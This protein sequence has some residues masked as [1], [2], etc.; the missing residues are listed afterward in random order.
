MDQNMDQKLDQKL[1]DKSEKD[2]PIK[3]Y[4][5]LVEAK[6]DLMFNVGTYGFYFPAVAL[7]FVAQY[8]MS[9]CH[10]TKLVSESNNSTYSAFQQV[11]EA[12]ALVNLDKNKASL[13]LKIAALVIITFS[14]ILMVSILVVPLRVTT[15]NKIIIF[16]P[17]LVFTAACGLQVF[18][19]HESFDLIVNN[20]VGPG[21]SSTMQWITITNVIFAMVLFYNT[22]LVNMLAVQLFVGS[23]FFMYNYSLHKWLYVFVTDG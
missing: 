23:V 14:M 18:M 22:L 15:V 4:D 17:F 11:N 13:R 1:I 20:N 12:E 3:Q 19:L 6:S 7:L 9:D 21:Y 10:N 8:V 16:I 5:L 2:K